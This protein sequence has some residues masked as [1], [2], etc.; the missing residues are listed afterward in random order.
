MPITRWAKKQSVP[1]LG[2]EVG[3]GEVEDKTA[4]HLLVEVVVEVV[5]CD[6]R[7]AEPRRFSATFQQTVA[8]T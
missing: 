4:I 6:L 3:D 8:A 1:V 5:E 7:I 2:D